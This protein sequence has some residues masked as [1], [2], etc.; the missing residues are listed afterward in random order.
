LLALA[1]ALVM[2]GSWSSCMKTPTVPQP[3]W[4]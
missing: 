4:N 3:N 2:L 1:N